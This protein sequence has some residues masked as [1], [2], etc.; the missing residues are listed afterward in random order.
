M[1]P[2]LSA[3]EAVAD[4]WIW[5]S[6]PG[7]GRSWPQQPAL[8]LADLWGSHARGQDSLILLDLFDF[9]FPTNVVLVE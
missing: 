5:C 7:R 4:K 6:R 1:V 9:G 8:T 3:G 2:A